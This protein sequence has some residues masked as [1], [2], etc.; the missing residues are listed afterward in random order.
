[1][2]YFVAAYREHGPVFFTRYRGEDWVTIAGIEAND[3]FWQNPGDWSY[4]EAGR[5]FR[6]QFG[7]TYVTQ[8][9]GPPHQR[10]RRLFKAG[11]SAESIGRLVPELAAAARDFL[12]GRGRWN[13]D[14][15]EWIPALLL[16]LNQ[17][18]LLRMDLDQD[19]MR[20]AIRLEGELIY[21]VGASADPDAF[22]ARP[23]YRERRERVFA[24]VGREADARLA[25][26]RTDDRLQAL[27]DQ[28]AGG[29]EPFTAEELRNAAYMLLVAGIHNTARLLA[30]VLERLSRDP[31]W[32]AELRGE[33][34]A[35][36][37]ASFASGLGAFPKL[38][39]T[40]LEGERLH[41]GGTFLKRRPRRDLSFAG[42][43]IPAG[44]KV[45]QA[46]ALPHFLPEFHPDPLRFSP[47]RWIDRPPP[48]KA[49]AD[50]GGGAHVCLG[51]N[52]TRVQAP[53]V[54]AEIL[55]RYD[56]ALAY[57]PDF[58]L[59]VDDGLGPKESPQPILLVERR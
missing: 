50:F 52:L 13:E 48:R 30:A 11:F 33:L 15:H 35:C 9:D 44:A 47:R 38:K 6:S 12:A 40:L 24:W 43:T 7:P 19:R 10:A 20:D 31:G 18:T 2:G 46:H 58:R 17:R 39:A 57:E 32:T 5:G 23:S 34:A 59:R 51:M 55:R 22:F 28:D 54:L 16:S 42:K 41:P 49:L 29:L 27:I 26:K 3:F 53:I 37:D 21:G 1:M 4:E 25:G 8:L 56:W 45:M 14:A 36:E